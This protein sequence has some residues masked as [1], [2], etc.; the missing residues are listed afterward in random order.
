MPAI[1]W[2]DGPLARHRPGAF[3]PRERELQAG[4]P[5][6]ID[7][8]EVYPRA[9]MVELGDVMSLH[10]PKLNH[11]QS[12]VQACMGNGTTESPFSISGELTQVLNLG[13]IA[14]YLNVELQFDPKTK[15]F[16]GNDEANARLAGPPPRAEWADCYKLA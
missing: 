6:P 15:R 13:T 11:F 7:R 1:Q 14:E 8:P 10:A 3:S 9:K 2:E 5:Q 16:I 12:F 4:K